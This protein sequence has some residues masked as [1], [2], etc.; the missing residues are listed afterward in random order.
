MPGGADLLTQQGIALDRNKGGA[1]PLVKYLAA[2][3]EVRDGAKNVAIVAAERGLSAK[4]LGLLMRSLNSRQPSPLL[5]SLRTHWRV[6]KPG[7][8]PA[9]AAEVAK[10]QQA[11]WKFNSVGHIG[12]AGGPKIVDGDRYRR[13]PVPFCRILN[14]ATAPK[15]M[16]VAYDEFRQ[17]FPAALCY[18]KIVPVDEVVTLTLFY[19]QDEPLARLLLDD[20][21]KA[22]LDRLWDELH[23]VSQDAITLVDA[24]EQLW[25][26][27]SQD[28]PDAPH[29]DKRLEP[30]REPINQRAVAFKQRLVDTQPR[31]LDAVLEFAEKAYRRP[32]TDNEKNELRGLYQKSPPRGSSA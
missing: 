11:L 28:G 24:F 18:T 2:S 23:F 12:M 27:S 30:L 32:I 8:V 4:Y 29:G 9:L 21:Q 6:A 26:Y 5:D 1:L 14:A 16:D 31:H 13:H 15:R 7:D 3:L 25:Q 17:M 19:R 10:W 22:Q 20:A